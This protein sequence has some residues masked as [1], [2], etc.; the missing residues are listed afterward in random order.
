VS[1]AD[2]PLTTLQ[3]PRA[4]LVANLAD[5]AVVRS[6]YDVDVLLVDLSE[7]AA[8]AVDQARLER[9][10]R[11]PSVTIGLH[12]EEGPDVLAAG[13]DVVA[14][15]DDTKVLLDAI[16]VAPHASRVL[17]Q[18]LRTSEHM[19]VGQALVVESLAYS[20]L[21]ASPEFERWLAGRPPRRA[22]PDPDELVLV[23]RTHDELHIQLNRPHVHNAYSAGLR[24]A[25]VAAL[26]VAILDTS[27]EQVTL[28][29][30]GPSFCS[31]GDLDEFGTADDV[32]VAHT[33]RTTSSAGAAIT[34]LRDRI[35]VQVHGSCVGAGVELP[36]FAG[37][38]VADPATSF[39]LPEVAMGLIPGAGGTVSIPRRVGRQR[40]TLFALSGQR[41]D[42][43]TA[44]AW[45]L[46]DRIEP[47][48]GHGGN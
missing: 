40:A 6:L 31:G 32:A 5:P 44:R 8:E 3:W 43:E 45:G 13:L 21:L 15:D 12:G 34:D 16:S 46:V 47:V 9:L 41:I 23:D 20:M 25:L 26:G 42:A 19:T 7:P 27:I 38:V 35:A 29:G 1:P 30:A 4:E 10:T 33:I 2:S 22:K 24:D 48:G 28:T 36:A 18:V 11:V 37:T 17:V 14:A 39:R